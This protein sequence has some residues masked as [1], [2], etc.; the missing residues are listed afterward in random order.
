LASGEMSV[1]GAVVVSAAE[2]VPA[3]GELLLDYR[4]WS[5]RAQFLPRPSR[6]AANTPSK[7]HR[8]GQ[9][10]HVLA[11]VDPLAWRYSFGFPAPDPRDRSDPVALAVHRASLQQ[12]V[13]RMMDPYSKGG[14]GDFVVGVP[15]GVAAM[16]EQRESLRRE[17]YG[18]RPVFPP[19]A[20][21]VIGRG[22]AGA[23]DRGQR[24]LPAATNE[25][26]ATAGFPAP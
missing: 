25:R 16:R 12:R 2:D 17:V 1:G 6:H 8:T 24:Q 14:R 5:Q 23:D 26:E 15:P 18:G 3:G 21:E 19:Q 10:R 22:P 13:S 4:D 7:L 20:P 11:D 9:G